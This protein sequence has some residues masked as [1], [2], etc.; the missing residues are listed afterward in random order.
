MTGDV[1]TA[2]VSVEEG[3]LFKGKIDI[4]KEPGKAAAAPAS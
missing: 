1:I 2:R 4:Q 3:A